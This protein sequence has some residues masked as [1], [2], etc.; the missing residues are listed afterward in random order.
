MQRNIDAIGI[1]RF[2]RRLVKWA[3]VVSL[4]I[5]FVPLA[6][7]AKAPHPKDIIF[8]IDNSGSMKKNDPGLVTK[9]IVAR[10]FDRLDMG[11][12]CGIVLFDSKARQVTPL[13]ELGT[14]NSKDQLISGLE[15]VDYRG[16]RTD[17]PAGI[18]RAI[19]ELRTRGRAEAMQC[20][21]FLTDG[22]VDTGSVQS[23]ADKTRWLRDDLALES[24]KAGIRIYGV[25]FTENADFQLIQSLAMKTDGAYFRALD[26]VGLEA[27]FDAIG[28][29]LASLGA[30]QVPVPAQMHEKPSWYLERIRD[31]SSTGSDHAATPVQPNKPFDSE[32]SA[33]GP[34]A[35]V[36][37]QLAA[38]SE[39]ELPGTAPVSPA[40]QTQPVPGQPSPDAAGN[41]GQTPVGSNQA[42]AVVQS[43]TPSDSE[44]AD[45]GT[46]DSVALRGMWKIYLPLVIIALL[47]I[48]ALAYMILKL[49]GAR[50]QLTH[51]ILDLL[52]GDKSKEEV[53]VPEAQLVNLDQA[54]TDTAS[55]LFIKKMRTTIG[56]NQSN[57]IVFDQ[58]TISSFHACITF[59]RDRFELE[60]YNSTNGSFVNNI[61]LEAET[62][63]HLKT[64][65]QIKFANY[66]FRFMRMDR[67]PDG[68]T[69]ML[70]SSALEAAAY[71]APTP[72]APLPAETMGA[73]F[74][75][76]LSRQL[77]RIS[78][79]GEPYAGF[80]RDHL[81]PHA[82]NLL[83]SRVSHHLN[84]DATGAFFAGDVLHRPPIA[85]K[86]CQLPV[87]PESAAA[88]F[89]EAHGG[90]LGFIEEILDNEVQQQ[91]GCDTLCLISYG[92]RATP[93]VSLSIIPVFDSE[94]PV[95]I[96][97][98][99]FLTQKELDMLG[100]E[101]DENGRILSSI[102]TGAV[103]NPNAARAG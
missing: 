4:S 6:A 14:P 8:V 16:Q 13:L 23:D 84:E 99:E 95:E 59:E 2:L 88:W 48:L 102:H 29:Q 92:W 91:P 33:G 34:P 1:N 85:F 3:M 7:G 63:K 15:L 31:V 78:D 40:P 5:V 76:V 41:Q 35:A 74:Q 69:V 17:S 62:P 77:D 81:N 67:I 80:V 21:I 12:R 50:G 47:L 68:Q 89:G 18:E 42:T 94:D 71:S 43:G 66:E 70:S 55:S 32:T 53:S 19:Y 60:D 93:W 57:D 26:A 38:P 45:R 54:C 83:S 27:A 73:H 58:P 96:I 90:F 82:Q 64:G 72:K 51:R 25:A 56:R 101:F 24:H 97:S 36:G 52:P 98:V 49:R 28:R 20:I 86:L 75:T 9:R 39:K 11:D 103:A 30:K 22:I 65:D 44:T 37:E 87:P 61:R 79:L 46:A 100:L 10:F